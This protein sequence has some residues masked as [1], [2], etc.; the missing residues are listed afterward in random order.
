MS[1]MF[2]LKFSRGSIFLLISTLC[3]DIIRHIGCVF[4]WE[5]NFNNLEVDQSL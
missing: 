2:I 3:D 1:F 4:L 5:Q